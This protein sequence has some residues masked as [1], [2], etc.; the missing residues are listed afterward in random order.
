MKK[1][2]TKKTVAFQKNAR[3]VFF[4]ILTRCNLRCQHCYI[5]PE[6]H[7]KKSLSL[8]TIEKWLKAFAPEQKIS[9]LILIGGEPTLHPELDLCIKSAGKMG[10]ASI[11]VDTN[12]FFFN[13]ILEKVSPQEVTRPDCSAFN[14]ACSFLSRAS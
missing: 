9:N 8:E 11:T 7:G 5:N 1:L 13:D 12:G 3:N 10:Y 4:H 6:E 14:S 2:N